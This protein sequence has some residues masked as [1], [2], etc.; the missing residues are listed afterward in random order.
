L[1][2]S[3][4][5]ICYR[6]NNKRHFFSQQ[7]QQN[8]QLSRRGIEVNLIPDETQLETYTNVTSNKRQN[9]I[10]TVGIEPEQHEERKQSTT[11]SADIDGNVWSFISLYIFFS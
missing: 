3:E 7:A 5:V 10:S 2:C 4:N 6:A 11:T 9:N 8:V 1:I